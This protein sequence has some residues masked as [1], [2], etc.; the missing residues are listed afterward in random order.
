MILTDQIFSI[1]RDKGNTSYFGEQVSQ[2]EHALQCADL[3]VSGQAEGSLVVAALLHDF[4]HLVHLL[5]EEIADKG[6]DSRHEYIGGAWLARHFRPEVTA[7]IRLHVAAKRYLCTVDPD[8]LSFL[9][10]ASIQSFQLQGGLLSPEEIRAFERQPHFRAAVDLR[11]WDDGAKVP[12][13]V[14]PDL[15][16]YRSRINAALTE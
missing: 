12:G 3:A 13:L 7:P 6:I 5:P 8:Y 4:G 16:Y 1:F 14:V 11:R 10:A 9:S 2:L 15:E